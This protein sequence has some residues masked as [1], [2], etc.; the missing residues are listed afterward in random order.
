MYSSAQRCPSTTIVSEPFTVTVPASAGAANVKPSPTVQIPK[1]A[2]KP[3]LV[4][5][6]FSFGD[7]LPAASDTAVTKS[8]LF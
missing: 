4:A 1:T 3:C 6:L 7:M 5:M 2:V 8:K